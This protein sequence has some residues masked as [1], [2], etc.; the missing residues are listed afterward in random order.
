MLFLW[1]LLADG[2]KSQ[3]SVKMLKW[4]WFLWK[5]WMQESQQEILIWDLAYAQQPRS[6]STFSKQYL[7]II[8]RFFFIIPYI[9]DRVHVILDQP[10]GW[11]HRHRRP[12]VAG[13]YHVYLLFCIILPYVSELFYQ[14]SILLAC[15]RA[16]CLKILLHRELKNIPE[17]W[18]TLCKN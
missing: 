13:H 12:P 17:Q 15:C 1:R 9:S 8:S 6:C 18:Y 4:K 2:R 10:S 3:Y 16:F 11:N 5:S 7:W 14:I